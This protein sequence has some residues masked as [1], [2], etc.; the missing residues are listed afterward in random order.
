MARLDITE[1]SDLVPEL[2]REFLL[3]AAHDNVRV[4]AQGLEF[5]D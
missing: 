2:R 3:R 1:E 4:D 5:L